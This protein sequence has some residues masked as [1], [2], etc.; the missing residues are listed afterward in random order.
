MTSDQV[1]SVSPI[2]FITSQ[3]GELLAV[4]VCVADE[5]CVDA[6][7][8][9]HDGPILC[10]FA[11]PLE[12]LWC[13]DGVTIFVYDS[14]CVRRFRRLLGLFEMASAQMRHDAG[15]ESVA[16]NVDH[17]S[18]TIPASKVDGKKFDKIADARS[19]LPPRQE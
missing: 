19:C 15:A 4:L 6:S 7:I 5:A 3:F 10:R 16:F 2:R 18:K 14:V 9:S 8:L 13:T 12:K 11:F 17:R 1:V